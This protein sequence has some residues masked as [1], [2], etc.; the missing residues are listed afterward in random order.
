MGQERWVIEETIFVVAR[1]RTTDTVTL[2]PH[3]QTF[4]T[5]SPQHP[6]DEENSTGRR[7]PGP[8]LAKRRADYARRTT[9]SIRALRCR[10]RVRMGDCEL[11]I[12]FRGGR[13]A[14]H[15]SR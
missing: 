7:D 1:I 9:E 5:I 12:R 8:M 15:W 14:H 13:L 10:G 4:K 3:M 6:V 11:L 2:S